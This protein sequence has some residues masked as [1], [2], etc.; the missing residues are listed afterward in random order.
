M[1][2]GTMRSTYTTKRPGTARAWASALAI[3]CLTA[4]PAAAGPPGEL[5]RLG[6]PRAVEESPPAGAGCTLLPE[7]VPGPEEVPV[8]VDEVAPPEKSKFRL[9]ASW[10]NGLHLD[11][12]D[13]RFR[14]HVGGNAQI[15]STWLIAPLGAFAIPGGGMNG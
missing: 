1:P 9:E 4:P 15:D 8:P 5:I 14:L 2:G 13:G 6:P 11:S 10:D 3:A 12:D 7:S